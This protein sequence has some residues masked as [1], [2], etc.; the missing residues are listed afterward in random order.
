MSKV[1]IEESTLDDIAN[2][3]QKQEGS[4]EKIPPLEMPARIEALGGGLALE[5]KVRE[6]NF[7]SLN[8]LGKSDATINLDSATRLSSLFYVENDADINTTVEHLTINCPNQVT[9]LNDA[10]N[11]KK[12]ATLKRITLNVDTSA[13]DRM[14]YAFA[15]NTV[16]E[17]I[18][19]TP[20]DVSN[21][22]VGSYLG[23]MFEGCYGL[24][25][26]RFK[27]TIQ[28]NISFNRSTDLDKGG[29]VNVFSCLSDETSGASVTFH[30]EAVN[31]A[32]ETS[33][34]AADGLTSAEW[35]ALVESKPNW[36]ISIWGLT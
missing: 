11:G 12:D 9:T 13:A 19:G 18:D 25:F 32:F 17:I 5:T 31:P 7:P 33:P 29:I 15:G 26:V 4:T 1:F 21:V 14:R 20:I 24:V 16:L 8:V 6:I 35:L 23:G 36:T 34:G 22:T 30:E 10:V 28:T 2:A 3:I 27:G